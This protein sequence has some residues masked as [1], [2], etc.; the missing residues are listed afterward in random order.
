MASSRL[1]IADA[2]VALV[3]T[4]SNPNTSQPLY[5]NVKLGATFDPSA[6][7]SW[8][9]IVHSQGQGTPAGSGGSAVGWRIDDSVRYLV[10]SGVGPYEIDSTA[11]QIN[12]LTI[13]D[14]LLPA[15]HTH[16]QLPDSTNPTTVV[17]S[18]Y[19]TLVDQPDKSM[20]MKFPNGHIYLLWH[21]IVVV[22]QQYGVILVQP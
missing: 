5:Q 4:F 22:K 13:Q 18:V 16:F 6:F 2:L 15:L 3:R 12:M 9:D 20:A 17:Q 1:A 19:S 11:A 21:V 14:V 10:T 8:C 7:T